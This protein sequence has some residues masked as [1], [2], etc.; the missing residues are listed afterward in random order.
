MSIISFFTPKT[1]KKACEQEGG[2]NS[3]SADNETQ[4]INSVEEP[5]ITPT[6]SRSKKTLVKIDDDSEGGQISKDVPENLNCEKSCEEIESTSDEKME[7]IIEGGGENIQHASI[8]VEEISDDAQGQVMEEENMEE[9]KDEEVCQSKIQKSK[10]RKKVEKKKKE[11]VITDSMKEYE[12]MVEEVVGEMKED[13][14]CGWSF[15][16]S[17]N[18]ENKKGLILS[19]IVGSS[20]PSLDQIYLQM[21]E[22]EGVGRVEV[23]EVVAEMMSYFSLPKASKWSSPLSLAGVGVWELRRVEEVADMV[24]EEDLEKL[25]EG[26]RRRRRWGMVLGK[27]EKWKKSGG[28]DKK[29]AFMGGRGE[30]RREGERYWERKEEKERRLVEKEEKR[31]EREEMAQMRGEEREIRNLMKVEKRKERE[32]RLALERE[33]KKEKERILKMKKKET[34]PPKV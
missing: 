14:I 21:E 5:T 23:E 10:R 11:V 31:R 20:S 4:D 8:M 9:K 32:T 27:L 15:S 29:M 19:R 1:L 6:M 26:R 7:E 30:L 17:F 33:E 2:E 34:P 25:K 22:E 3:E 16:P 24:S 13:V 28:E 18:Q 12:E